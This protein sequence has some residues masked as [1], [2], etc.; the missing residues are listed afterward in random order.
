MALESDAFLV[1][2]SESGKRV[3]DLVRTD[4]RQASQLMEVLSRDEQIALVS[5]QASK[6]PKSAQEL[7]FLLDDSQGRD[8]VDGLGDRSL[9][10]I[11]KSQSSTHIGVLSLVDPGRIQNILD[12]DTE[13]FSAKGFTDPQSAYQWMVSFLE[14]EDVVF[15][16]LLHKLDIKVVASAF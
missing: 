2:I 9:F 4:P 1:P 7:I 15:A 11:M 5:H 6:D 13:L 8:L 3:L 12:L 10:R 16:E 14:E